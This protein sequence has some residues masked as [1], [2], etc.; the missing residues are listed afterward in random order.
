MNFEYAQLMMLRQL[1]G[2]YLPVVVL[3]GLF[4]ALLFR[5]ESITSY[6]L[7]KVGYILFILSLVV[8]TLVQSFLVLVGPP[9]GLRGGPSAEVA[10][11]TIISSLGPICLAV[12]LICILGSLM[13]SLAT[14]LPAKPPAAPQKHPLDE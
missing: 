5:R 4:V 6:G 12:G 13:P 2:D 8:P 9:N 10:S 1:S 14:R 3:S 7:F 11:F